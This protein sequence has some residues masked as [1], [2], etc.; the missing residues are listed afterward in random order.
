MMRKVVQGLVVSLALCA[1]VAQGAA[2]GPRATTLDGVVEGEAQGGV[3]VYRGI[4]FAAAPVGEGRWRAP[5]P[6]PAWQGVRP[7]K[8]FGH[9]CWQSVS[10]KGFGPWTHE[11]VVQGDIS[12]DCL[13]LNVWTGQ[14][15]KA[16]ARPVLVWLHGGGFNSGSG[17][18]PIYDGARLARQGVVVVTINY[19]VGALGFLAHPELTREAGGA[20]GTNFGLLDMVA[21]LQW[22]K[23]NIKAFGGDPARVTIAGQSA[24]AMAVQE[25][26]ASPLARGLFVRAIAESGLPRALPTLARAE[27]EGLA[28]QREKGAASL[29]VLRAMPVETLQPAQGAN[30]VRF[31]PVADGAFLPEG[32]WKPASNVPMLAGFVA[33]EGSSQGPAEYGSS[34][35][36]RLDGLLKASYG[37][38][39]SAFVPLYPAATDNERA[40]AN[41]QI[42][43][44]RSLAGL[45]AWSRRRAGA[46]T[47]AYLFTHVMPGAGSDHWGAFHSSEIPYV[48]Q[49]FDASPERMFTPADRRLSAMMSAYWVN[50][51]ATGHPDKGPAGDGL[52]PWPRLDEGPNPQLLRIG[53]TVAPAPVLGARQR[54]LVEED[55]AAHGVV[56]GF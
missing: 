34:D 27:Q 45:Y 52:A 19:R 36:A 18:I 8:A 13:F 3:A 12:E 47:Y 25:L 17:A 55:L 42:R 31:G 5:Q 6:F 33:D 38:R 26:V 2:P 46:L 32:P 28:F 51:I 49:T 50:F 24:G 43:R 41:R 11:Y 48:F 44:D 14:G 29:E 20:Q 39:A 4:P 21:A 37:A 56:D 23:N 16:A 1:G 15:S 35:A 30:T 9:S 54:A 22:V 7:A 53:D 10:P 40:D